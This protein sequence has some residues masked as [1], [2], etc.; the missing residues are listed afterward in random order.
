MMSNLREASK[1]A[2]EAF[3]FLHQRGGLGTHVHE[4]ILIKI[5]TLREALAEPDVVDPCEFVGLT[6]AEIISV[7]ECDHEGS[8][9]AVARALES[10]IKE[11]N[12]G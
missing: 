2:L 10:L 5:K 9:I 8:F 7:F 11:K 4:Y 1:Q 12:N 3:E 6:D